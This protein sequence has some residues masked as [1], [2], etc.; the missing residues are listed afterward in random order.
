MNPWTSQEFATL[1]LGD[2]RLNKRIELIADRFA[3]SPLSPINNA[4]DNWS[5]TK[6]AYRFFSNEKVDYTQICKSHIDA[7]K[8][9]CRDY[10]TVLAIQD[11]SYCSYAQHPKTTGLCPISL[12]NGKNRGEIVSMGLVM[13]STFMVNTDGLPLGIG[14]QKI[15]SRPQPAMKLDA[16]QKKARN[17]RLPI[18]DKDSYRWIE[19]LQN[20]HENF[21][22]QRCRVVTIGDREADIYDM[23]LRANQLEAPF[24]IRANHNRTINSK[25]EP[26]KN[27]ERLWD[28]LQRQP[29]EAQIQVKVPKHNDRAERIASCEVRCAPYIMNIPENYCQGQKNNPSKLDLYAIYVSEVNCPEGCEPVDWMLSTNLTIL[30]AEQALEKVRWYCLR[31][32]IETW[33]KILKSGLQIEKCRLSTAPRL[34]RYLAVMSIVAWR[35]FWITLIARSSPDVSCTI[36]LEEFEWKILAAKYGKSKEQKLKEPTLEQSIIWI[37]RL[38]GFLARKGDEK[39]GITHIWRGLKKFAAMLEGAALAKDICG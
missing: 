35:I 1:D 19:S 5:E 29:C 27:V 22:A 15:Y 14:D 28:Y 24:V 3:K 12:H 31:W 18:E 4:C 39:P 16:K 17:D 10:E 8:T 2:E 33:H 32:R 26:E 6:A 30:N 25:S 36:L 20:T 11:T 34:T 7:T 21:S 37:A 38:G 13:H 23:F 9:R